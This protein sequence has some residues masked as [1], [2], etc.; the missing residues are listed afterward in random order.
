MLEEEKKE[1]IRLDNMLK[2]KKYF[3]NGD[4]K[5]VNEFDK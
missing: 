1:K 2:I 5:Y 4:V 3:L